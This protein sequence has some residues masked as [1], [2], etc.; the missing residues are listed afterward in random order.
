[1]KDSSLTYG[2]YVPQATHE[3]EDSPGGYYERVSGTVESSEAR[4]LALVELRRREARVDLD[5]SGEARRI[6]EELATLKHS[7]SYRHEYDLSHLQDQLFSL[8][9][10]LRRM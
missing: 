7:A 9:K 5:S 6:L 10:E 8:S 2:D 4:E 3:S 1:L